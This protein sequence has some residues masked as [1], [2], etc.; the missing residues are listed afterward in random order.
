MNETSP[1]LLIGVG[2][3]G[4]ASARGVNRAS[5]EGLRYVLADS[6]ASTGGATDPF[7][8]LGGDRLSGHGSGGDVAQARLAAE[9][10]RASFDDVI[11]GVRLAVIVAC[12]G[13][14][15]GS[16]A[17]LAIARHLRE[18][19]VPTLVF[20]TLPFT[21]EGEERRRSADGVTAAIASESSASVFLPL[22]KLVGDVDVMDEALRR[23]VDTLA[24]GIT[25]FWRLL[26][27]PGYIRLDTEHIRRIIAKAGNGRFAVVTTQGPDRSVEA[28][29]ALAR[30]QLLASGT[31]PVRSILCGVLAGEDLRLSEI[32]KIADG[33]RATFGERCSFD[34]GTVNDEATFSGRISVVLL[35][36]ES[37]GT[38]DEEDNSGQTARGKRAHKSRNPLAQG[39]QGRG[40]FNNVEP[41]VW[42]NE[43]L[44]TPTFIRRNVTLDI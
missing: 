22:D 23:A 8:L 14:G 31:S 38:P 35:L 17:T 27:K 37:N 40:R 16:G 29:D 19:G 3:A 41:T 5:G 30:S 44:D 28:V 9:D 25:L 6:D 39:P 2:G 42:R 43:D 18:R 1:L 32:G 4:A 26:A 34:L 36:F 7:I 24:S 11:E 15:V 21:F 20:A 33:V 12:L 13:G 10:S